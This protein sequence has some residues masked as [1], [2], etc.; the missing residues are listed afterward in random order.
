MAVNWF[1]EDRYQQLPT[2][3][4]GIAS[5]LYLLFPKLTYS[6]QQHVRKK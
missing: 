4:I 1:W 3:K 6:A 5:L 2:L